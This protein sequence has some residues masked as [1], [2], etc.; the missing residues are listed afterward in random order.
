MR[1]SV[2]SAAAVPANELRKQ[3]LKN[4]RSGGL[5]T[6]GVIV[7]SRFLDGQ[8]RIEAKKNELIHRHEDLGHLT[9]A[10]E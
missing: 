3:F 9:N 7:R 1:S 10:I 5:Q 8:W 4:S 6:A 2:N